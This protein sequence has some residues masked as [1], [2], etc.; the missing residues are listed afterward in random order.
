MRLRKVVA[1][2]LVSRRIPECALT[3]AIMNAPLRVGRYFAPV[4]LL[5]LSVAAPRPGVAATGMLRPMQRCA[6]M[7]PLAQA[8]L[9]EPLRRIAE[10][11]DELGKEQV[12]RS[13]Y[14]GVQLDAARDVVYVFSTN[15]RAEHS[16][17]T[18]ARRAA[19][20]AEWSRVRGKHAGYSRSA[21]VAA[22]A[23]IMAAPHHAPLRAVSVPADGTG[24]DVETAHGATDPV[25]PAGLSVPVRVR[26]GPARIA[27]SWADAK[28][29]D[30]SPFIGGDA[31]TS[32]GNNLCT[33][34]LPAVRRTDGVPVMITAGHCFGDRRHGFTRVA[35]PLAISATT[36]PETTSALSGRAPPNGTPNRLPAP[37]TLPMKA[38]PPGT[39]RSPASPTATRATTYAMTGC[40][41]S[42]STIRHRAAS[43]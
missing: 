38:T 11:V 40:G 28:W 35:A 13:S 15:A 32:N 17:L 24:V 5:V 7:S 30:S 42:S 41:R 31:L 37:R 1:C 14:S 33:A 18:A 22:A 21:L 8:S 29:H 20:D 27:K 19:P 2:W 6:A 39:N 26:R 23:R 12:W 9:L 4:V 36:G 34:G 25:V 43:R 3:L 16:L 10:V